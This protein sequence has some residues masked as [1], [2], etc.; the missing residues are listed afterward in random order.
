MPN[1]III[2]NNSIVLILAYFLIEQNSSFQYFR[3]NYLMNSLSFLSF[4]TVLFFY[5]RFKHTKKINFFILSCAIVVNSL[6][7]YTKISYSILL[8]IYIVFFVI[9][10]L[11]KSDVKRFNF[12]MNKLEKLSRAIDSDPSNER[13][14]FNCAYIYYKLKGV[15][16][17]VEYLSKALEI[18]PKYKEAYNIRDNAYVIIRVE[19]VKRIEDESVII[20]LSQ[21]D[22]SPIVRRAAVEKLKDQ[23]I[24]SEIARND[25]DTLVQKIAAEKTGDKLLINEVNKIIINTAKNDKNNKVRAEVLK[26]IDDESVIIHMAQKDNSPIVRRTAVE[27]LKDQDILS[28]IARNDPDTFVQK[29]AAEKTGDKIL[30][31]E[32]NKIL[33]NTAKNDENFKVRAEAVKTIDDESIIIYL[34][35][36]DNSPV[37][38]RTAVEKLNNQNILSEIVLNDDDVVVRIE[39][40]E[41]IIN[42]QLISE[43]ARKDSNRIVREFAAEKTG[44][45]LLI[46]TMIEEGIDN[47]HFFFDFQNNNSKYLDVGNALS[48]DDIDEGVVNSIPTVLMECANFSMAVGRTNNLIIKIPTPRTFEVFDYTYNAKIKY[49]DLLGPDNMEIDFK[50]LISFKDFNKFLGYS[51]YGKILV[52][53]L[54]VFKLQYERLKEISLQSIPNTKFIIAKQRDNNLKIAILQEKV[55]GITLWDMFDHNHKILKEQYK[56]HLNEITLQIYPFLNSQYIDYNAK[57]FIYDNEVNRLYYV[58]S[59][60]PTFYDNKTNLKSRSKIIKFFSNLKIDPFY[61]ILV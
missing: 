25:P 12:Y 33:I 8:P 54:L 38:R 3:T 27:K 42:N 39:A 15:Q 36:K 18:N 37:V 26:K 7:Y 28:E 9:C 14:Y 50:K 60:P 34:A 55:K 29:I 32:V 45:E 23:K 6:F 47:R 19:A 48:I 17:A 30:I 10:I 52:H 56:Y 44:D 22:N 58:G 1:F 41:K 24:L 57:N 61:P 5:F 11:I 2:I 4:C 46:R 59:T 53:F 49:P 20:Y 31:N 35:Q 21:M 43:I 13:N 40:V 51:R 16:Y